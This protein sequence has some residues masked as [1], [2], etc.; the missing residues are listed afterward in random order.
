MSPKSIEN[1]KHSVV[2]KF[3]FW[4]ITNQNKLEF[5][6]NKIVKSLF[7]NFMGMAVFSAFGAKAL[8]KLFFRTELPVVEIKL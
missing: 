7:I 4:S 5:N 1:Y 3:I 6:D 8:R 2:K